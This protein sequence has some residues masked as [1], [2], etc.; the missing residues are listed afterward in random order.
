MQKLVF[1]NGAGNQ[2]DLTA[3]NFGIT[4]WTGLSNTSLNIQTQQVPFEDGGVFL[5]ALME[6]REIEVTVAIYDGNNLE[7]RYQKKREL[8][9]ALNIWA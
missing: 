7:L 2:I 3:G 1:I 9:S 6:Q 4:N 5:D 8:I